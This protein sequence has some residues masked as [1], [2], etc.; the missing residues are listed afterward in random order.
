MEWFSLTGAITFRSRNNIYDVLITKT[1]Y[2]TVQ[3]LII[4]ITK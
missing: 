2:E 1:T 3:Q 4:K